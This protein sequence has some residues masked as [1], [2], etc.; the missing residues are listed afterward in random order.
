MTPPPVDQAT[1]ITRICTLLS[2]YK[3]VD[4]ARKFLY[5][6]HAHLKRFCT[7]CTPRRTPGSCGP[8][9][10]LL[11]PHSYDKSSPCVKW[12]AKVK[13]EHRLYQELVRDM[14]KHGRGA[15]MQR[16]AGWESAVEDLTQWAQN[17]SEKNAA[18]AEEVGE[19]WT[20]TEGL[21]LNWSFDRAW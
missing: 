19:G 9:C 20:S 3:P 14:Q 1:R 8:T 11:S 2:Q 7:I 6:Q 21:D 4:E 16:V 10:S 18:E 17:L 15:T 5:T 12:L 13:S